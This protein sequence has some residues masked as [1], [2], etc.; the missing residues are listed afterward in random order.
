MSKYIFVLDT[1]VV[2]PFSSIE[3]PTSKKKLIEVLLEYFEIY[4]PNEVIN[5]MKKPKEHL[6][7][8]DDISLTWERV[9]KN[10]KDL[11]PPDSC[12]A[13]VQKEAKFQT[14]ENA[15]IPAEYKV[16]ALGLYLSRS[17]K[18]PIIAVIHEKKAF[19]LLNDIFRKQQCGCVLSPFDILTFIHVY[20]DVAYDDVNY[21]W[22]ELCGFKGINTVLDFRTVNYNNI[23]EVCLSGCK[24]R[25]CKNA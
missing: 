24:T 3:L 1:G 20:M 18:L 6:D 14:K 19:N 11:A 17:K 15:Q 25:K 2:L 12:F 13:V 10:I 4:V 23:L 5:E 7:N 9:K 22:G 8:W 21:A 16:A